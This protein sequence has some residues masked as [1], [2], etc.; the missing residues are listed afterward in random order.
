M[1]QEFLYFLKIKMREFKRLK[2]SR[3][4]DEPELTADF[5]SIETKLNDNQTM[6]STSVSVSDIIPYIQ[7]LRV[8]D[9]YNEQAFQRMINGEIIK[10]ISNEYLNKNKS[11]PNNI[12]LAFNPDIY[13]HGRAINFAGAKR[14]KFYKEFGS[15][16][17]IDGQHRLLAHL[18]EKNRDY[19]KS[20]LVNVILFETKDRAKAFDQMAELFYLINTKQK[21]LTSLVSLRIRSKI[22]PSDMES[23]WYRVFEKLNNMDQRDNYLFEKISFDE[24]EIRKEKNGINISSII[25]Y[26][27]LKRI[28]N[29][30]K[31]GKKNLIGL[32]DIYLQ[33]VVFKNEEQFYENFVRKYFSIIG[34]IID[35]NTKM[36]A[37]DFGGLLRIAIHFLNDSKTKDVFKNF[38]LENNA[39]PTKIVEDIKSYFIRIPFNK[40]DQLEYGANAWAIMEGFFL[41]NIRKHHRGFGISSLLSKKGQAAMKKG[42]KF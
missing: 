7:V 33:Q 28:S 38:A 30:V 16:I 36:A 42:K 2:G 23:I 5:Q 9:E 17:V 26:S 35:R 12:I 39:L 27:G 24:K 13:N 40:L 18:L 32:K 10:R 29:G 3:V 34:E 25:S 21:K 19:L 1:R 15:L 14:I 6:Y 22:I 8:A 37:R 11:F 4:G 31:K 20:V 41:G